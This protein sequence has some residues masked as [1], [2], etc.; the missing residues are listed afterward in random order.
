MIMKIQNNILKIYLIIFVTLTIGMMLHFLYN[1]L[2]YSTIFNNYNTISDIFVFISNRNVIENVN[3]INNISDT[4]NNSSETIKNII[5]N[6]NIA[7]ENSNNSII[8]DTESVNT[9]VNLSQLYII[10]GF[11]GVIILVGG[12]IYY[13]NITDSSSIPPDTLPHV[14]N[15]NVSDAMPTFARSNNI[16]NVELST[17]VRNFNET[18]I[19]SSHGTWHW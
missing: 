6:S 9:S 17:I 8:P 16:E 18:S 14:N 11:C 13:L 7:T 2:N 19:I 5:N 3:D 10:L 4:I 12:I 1:L 15:I